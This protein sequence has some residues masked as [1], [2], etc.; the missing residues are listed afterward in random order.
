[1]I[2]L[3]ITTSFTLDEDLDA[4]TRSFEAEFPEVGRKL[5]NN[6]IPGMVNALQYQPGPPDYPIKWASDAQRKYV[7]AL[8]RAT[9]NIPYQRTGLTASHWAATI[10]TSGAAFILKVFND[11]VN[12]RGQPYAE[13]VYGRL[14]QRS[15][16]EAIQSQ[17]PFHRGR[18]PLAVRAIRP[19]ADQAEQL[20]DAEITDRF[21]DLVRKK[22][23]RRSKR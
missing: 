21:N 23:T 15:D 8:L 13:F 1:M 17:Q 10:D 9:G 22:I 20:I 2:E 4:F 3:T 18:W 6:I 16:R 19:W 11:A 5:N 14:N 12:E 7:M